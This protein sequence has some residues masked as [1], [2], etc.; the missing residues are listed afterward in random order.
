MLAGASPCTSLYLGDSGSFAGGTVRDSS[1][2]I[3]KFAYFPV[4]FL[5]ANLIVAPLVLVIIYGT[6][7]SFVLSPFTVL[8]IWVVKRIERGVA[9]AE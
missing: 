2:V 6:V 9:V 5:P 8:H 7:A 1:V 3:Y 4:Y